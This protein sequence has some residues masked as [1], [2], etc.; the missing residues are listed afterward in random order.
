M[1]KSVLQSIGFVSLVL[2]FLTLFTN[3]IALVI[4]GI[5]ALSLAV[6]CLNMAERM[7]YTQDEKRGRTNKN[8]Q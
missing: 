8:L 2:G 3:S 1:K 6:I 7:N 5:F 4:M